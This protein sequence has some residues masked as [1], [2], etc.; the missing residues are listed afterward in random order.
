MP[1]GKDAKTAKL[2]LERGWF[3]P[4]RTTV[5]KH[6]PHANRQ[7]EEVEQTGVPH[8]TEGG[9]GKLWPGSV[10]EVPQ[11]DARKMVASGVASLEDP[12][13]EE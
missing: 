3:P 4:A 9:H 5:H 12:F 13:P 1:S 2:R 11:A 6:G 7:G 8:T 10:V